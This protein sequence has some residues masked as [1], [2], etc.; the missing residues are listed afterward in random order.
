MVC[1]QNLIFEF[2]KCFRFLNLLLH[3]NILEAF[4]YSI[5]FWNFMLHTKKYNFKST[6]NDLKFFVSNKQTKIYIFLI[7]YFKKISKMQNYVSYISILLWKWSLKLNPFGNTHSPKQELKIF[8]NALKRN[9]N[10]VFFS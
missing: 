2:E 5:F 10:F 6:N 9:E 3:Y 8:L 1:I 7:I 4:K